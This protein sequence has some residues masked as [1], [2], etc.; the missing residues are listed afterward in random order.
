MS[1]WRE[2]MPTDM[3]LRSGPDWQSNSRRLNFHFEL[4]VDPA[5]LRP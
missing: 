2:Q 5:P 1:F 3:F 4:D